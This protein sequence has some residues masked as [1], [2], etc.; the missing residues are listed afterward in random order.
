MFLACD[1]GN[2][3]IKTGLYSDNQLLE[4]GVFKSIDEV[5]LIYSRNDIS[6]TGIS[7]VVPG[8]TELFIEFLNK[9]SLLYHLITVNSKLNLSINYKTPDTLGIDRI[10]SA[11]G[12]FA[13]NGEMD[14]NEII[15]S[16]D[17]GTATTINVILYPGE[18]IG[19]VIAPGVNMMSEALHTRT[20]QLPQVSFD[21]FEDIIGKSTKSSIASGLINST[22]GMV[23]RILDII[24]KT[25]NTNN[26]KVFITGG[27]AERI[28]PYIKFDF[29]FEK[30]LVLYGIK[31]ISDLNLKP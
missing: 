4:S 1:I 17:F 18:F 28:I 27:N 30:A 8:T 13:L 29:V 5:T 31:S 6:N 22:L 25:Y 24:S 26:I 16:I 3:Q 10:C 2:S 11:E 19:G 20:A 21:D 7:S 9:K 15:L 12:A 23:D 14:K